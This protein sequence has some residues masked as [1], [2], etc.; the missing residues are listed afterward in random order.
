M[1]P[2]K[3]RP[4]DRRGVPP[5]VYPVLL[6]VG[7]PCDGEVRSWLDLPVEATIWPDRAK[8][9]AYARESRPG[10]DVWMWREPIR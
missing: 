10:G 4:V 1:R 9:G 5:V 2:R 3:K 8:G 6:C 7:G